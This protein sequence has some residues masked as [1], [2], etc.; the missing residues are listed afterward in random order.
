MELNAEPDLF[1]HVMVFFVTL[2]DLAVKMELI[3][4]PDL[5]AVMVFFVTL[6]DLAMKMEFPG[7]LVA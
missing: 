4:V 2:L 1:F 5:A 7:E 3:A 6:P